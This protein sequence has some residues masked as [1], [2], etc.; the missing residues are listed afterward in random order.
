MKW[1]WS[2]QECGTSGINVNIAWI[3]SFLAVLITSTA[4]ASTQ[5]A[6]NDIQ[7]A[8]DKANVGDT[9][10]VGPGKYSPFEVGK[11]L[12][13][14]GIDNPV[15]QAAVQS[16]GITINADRVMVSGFKIKGFNEGSASKF[17]Y[18]MQ[19]PATASL[20]LDLPNAGILV[21][22]NDAIING[23]IISGAQVGLYA[24]GK[25]NLSIL[26]ATFD[27]CSIGSQVLNCRGGRISNCFLSNSDKFGIDVEHSDNFEIENNSLNETKNSGILLKETASCGISNNTASRSLE[28]IALWNSSLIDVRRNIVDRSYYAIL[29]SGSDN[30]TILDNLVKDNKRNEIAKGGFGVGIS[31]QENSSHNII[32]RN[33]ADTSYNGIELIRGCKD[34]VIYGNNATDNTHG[35]RVD[36]NYNNLIYRNNFIGNT[37]SAYDNSTHNFWNASIGNYYSDYRGTDGDKDGIGDQPYVIPMGNS[38]AVDFRPLMMPCSTASLNVSELKSALLK[39]A[40]Y[41]PEEGN[42]VPY[43]RAGGMIIIGSKNKP[44]SPPQWPE[45]KPLFS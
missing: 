1:P 29:V 38:K 33:N 23:I 9:I 45:S 24:N 27:H 32:A 5:Q 19:H 42:D 4:F 7:A 25:Q 43:R 10:V 21:A 12:L 22:G 30:N 13:I 37:I 39:Y 15:I 8:I 6:G 2:S 40:R 17:E 11:P 3:L 26:N 44:T 20:K 41:N 16:P 31:L 35:I 14:V 34:N 18:Y 28:G 36:K